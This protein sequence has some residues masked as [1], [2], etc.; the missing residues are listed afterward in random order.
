S[1]RAIGQIGMVKLGQQTVA[2]MALHIV[3][4]TLELPLRAFEAIDRSGLLAALTEDIVVIASAVVGIPHLCINI[5][6][7]LACLAYIGWLSP[8]ILACGVIFAAPAIAASVLLS[9]RGVRHLR[10]ARA[11]QDTLVGHF[12]TLIDGFRELK[13]HRGR[14]ESYLSESLAP[15]M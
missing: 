2:D 12:R 6:I 15:T 14:R 13:L 10:R 5:P 9:A 7:V 4:R 11:G 1:A 8:L 3:R